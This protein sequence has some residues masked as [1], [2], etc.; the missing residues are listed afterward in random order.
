MKILTKYVVLV[1]ALMVLSPFLS[2]AEERV[3]KEEVLPPDESLAKETSEFPLQWKVSSINTNGNLMVDGKPFFPLGLFSCFGIDKASAT[4]PHSKYTGEVT[5]E[6]TMGRLKAIKDAGFNMLQT[7]TMQGYGNKF[8][9]SGKVVEKT[10][11]EKLREGMIKFMDY[12]D[13]AGLK[14]MIGARHP[15]CIM[16]PLPEE[17]RAAEWARRKRELKANIDA[18][19]DHPAL[20]VWYLIDEPENVNMP[21]EDLIDT[22]RY[23][24]SLDSVHPM[25][26]NSPFA[27]VVKYRRGTDIMAE[28][29]YPIESNEPITLI[30]ERLDVIKKSQIGDPPM[31]QIWA[32]I[33]ICQW[34]E[35]K[36]L[37]S[38][39][40]MRLMALLALT[41]D[42]K[43]FLFYEHM[44]YPENNPHR[45][46]NISRV[47]KSLY[48]VI[49]DL[50]ASPDIVKDYSVSDKRIS[51][52]MRRVHDVN[53]GHI[54]Y[55]LIAVNPTQ[56]IVYDPVA[57]GQATFTFDNLQVEE[58]SVVTVLDEDSEG[59]FKLGSCRQ[60]KLTKTNQGY[61]FTDEFGKLASHV[62]R[63]GVPK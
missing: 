18:W 22:Y 20:L 54:Y 10:T 35:G 52:I 15:Y 24:K 46:R 19:K 14:V 53:T 51:T 45:W 47:V 63:I 33:Q 7:Y 41:R 60:I 8:D 12:C 11:P 42:I 57:V 17:G 1:F 50:L 16:S 26:F 44:N 39:E 49:P 58:G 34:V 27:F 9:E 23:I 38:T 30:T 28:S 25:L 3:K 36:R 6:I 13:E 62:Y 56:N 59:N 32:V 61:S 48:S 5:K 40:E 21:V 29:F 4:H 37:P 43:G 31:P 2:Y 55:S